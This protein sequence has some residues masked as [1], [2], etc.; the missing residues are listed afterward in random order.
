MNVLTTN[1]DRALS[2]AGHVTQNGL[3]RDPCEGLEVSK[4]SVVEMATAPLEKYKSPAPHP[5]RFKIYRWQDTVSTEVSKFTGN[6]DGFG[7]SFNVRRLAATRSRSW[8]LE[9]VC[10][11]EERVLFWCSQCGYTM[12]THQLPRGPMCDWHAGGMLVVD[13]VDWR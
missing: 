2:W 3:L 7:V 13:V 6:A 11:R 8:A 9:T 4:T 5:K 1:R 10:V 12:E